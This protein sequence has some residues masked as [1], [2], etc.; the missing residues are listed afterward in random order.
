M[1][2]A[3]QHLPY[4]STIHGWY[5]SRNAAAVC[6]KWK[7][8]QIWATPAT[9][10][11]TL[12]SVKFHRVPFVG[13][14]KGLATPPRCKTYQTK[15]KTWF[16][17]L[18]CLYAVWETQIL[19]CRYSNIDHLRVYMLEKPYTKSPKTSGIQNRD[20]HLQVEKLYVRLTGE[21]HPKIATSKA[22]DSFIFGIAE[23]FGDFLRNIMSR[24]DSPRYFE[25][26]SSESSKSTTTVWFNKATFIYLP[27]CIGSCSNQQK[28][29]A[30]TKAFAWFF[31]RRKGTFPSLPIM[32]INVFW[33]CVVYW[34][35][36]NNL[37]IVTLMEP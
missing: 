32:I 26:P 1:V 13:Y 23:T 28:C 22:Q 4:R 30:W 33:F 9:T 20:T 17:A 10:P 37:K 15:Q 34:S 25:R 14:Y 7:L 19:I 16:V 5:G 11:R 12:D 2:Y 8:V 3:N 18:T 21:T 6:R 31:L 36:S 29:G 35:Y 24:H 27:Q